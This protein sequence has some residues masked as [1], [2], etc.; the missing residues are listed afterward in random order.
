MHKL[1]ESIELAAELHKN[2]ENRLSKYF[3]SKKIMSVLNIKHV[4][5]ML[6]PHTPFHCA[7]KY[8]LQLSCINLHYNLQGISVNKQLM[9][10]YIL[11]L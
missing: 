6:K 11:P 2:E 4:I 5:S 8:I 7:I 10:S 3:F 1:V 9:W